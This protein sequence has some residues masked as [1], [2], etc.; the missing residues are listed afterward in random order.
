MERGKKRNL[1][2]ADLQKQILAKSMKTDVDL[3]GE[4]KRPVAVIYDHDDGFRVQYGENQ[5][6]VPNYGY[7]IIGGETLPLAVEAV[8]LR[9][10]ILRLLDRQKLNLRTLEMSC[11]CMRHAEADGERCYRII[12]PLGDEEPPYTHI[13]VVVRWDMR[14]GSSELDLKEISQGQTE[15]YTTILSVTADEYNLQGVQLLAIEITDELPMTEVI[16]M[17]YR[18]HMSDLTL[19]GAYYAEEFEQEKARFFAEMMEYC[20]VLKEVSDWKLQKV[21]A[22][23]LVIASEQLNRTVRARFDVIGKRK[24]EELLAEYR[25]K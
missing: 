3:W 6:I 21:R 7:E 12:D 15:P 24:L 18:R 16:A 13:G 5:F 2:L 19:L 22:E 14:N 25:A 20:N 9:D 10:H 17:L 4:D 1:E 8:H 11:F 23:D